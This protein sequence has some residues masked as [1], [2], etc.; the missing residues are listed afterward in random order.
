MTS[1]IQEEYGEDEK[2]AATTKKSSQRS[3]AKKMHAAQW[4]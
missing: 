2:E 3:K 1:S 4:A